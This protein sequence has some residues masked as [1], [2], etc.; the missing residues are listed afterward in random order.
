MK[1]W[2]VFRWCVRVPWNI[3]KWLV[4][5]GR[6]LLLSARVWVLCVL[7]VIA[8]LVAYYVLSDRYTPFTTDAYV[9]AFVIQVAA[10]VEGQ[11][12]RVHVLENQAIRKG[13]R[14]FEIDPRPFEHRVALLEAKLVQA[15][16]QVAQME[17][18]LA[19]SK[20]DDARIVAEEAYARAV[21][22]QETQIRKQDATT[23]RKYLDAVQKYRAA[24]ADRERSRATTRK[25]EQALA[26]RIGG[27]HAIVAEVKAQLA[28]AKLN[29]SW[30][31][32][33]APAD[34]Y[35][36]NVQLREG[37]YVH[38]G[39]P[40]LTCIDSDQWWVVANYRENSLEYLQPGQR[41][42]LSFNTY[43]GRIFP[44]LVKT[45]GW[46]VY[47]GQAAPSGSLPA[48]HE[49]QNWIRLAQRFQVWVSPQMPAGYPLRIGATAS[50]AV[51]PREEYWLNGVTEAWHKVVA[52]FDYLR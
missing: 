19:A 2:P 45:V 43:P 8:A 22:E 36:T 27:E 29:L 41:V 37:S 1:A 21:H 40:V 26:A 38:V 31:R 51:Y 24:Q 3:L 7:L 50:V 6:T 5:S 33:D 9:Q 47:Q 39:T 49:P 52:A 28:E 17:S 44:G 16:Q 20:A 46:G 12:V 13:D 32:I 10:R 18:E 30:T 14:L 23:D 15:I 42:G 11:V 48:V 34:G 25:V 35:V 4:A